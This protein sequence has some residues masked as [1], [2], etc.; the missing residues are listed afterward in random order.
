MAVYMATVELAAE[1]NRKARNREEL[2]EIVAFTLSEKESDVREA[3]KLL[4]ERDVIDADGSP[5]GIDAVSSDA[6]RAKRYRE[7]KKQS[8]DASRDD[9]GRV[10]DASRLERPDQRER[11]KDQTVTVTPVIVDKSGA[12]SFKRVGGLVS[13]LGGLQKP[14]DVRDYLQDDDFLE[15]GQYMRGWDRKELFDKF[16][17]YFASNPPKN[18][19]AAFIGWVKKFTKGKVP[20]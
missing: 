19:K 6:E 15:V 13:G 8:R 17:A 10:H 14:Y 16:S 4:E 18:H 5:V 1:D 11:E 9:N 2:I 3:I 12:G 7:K 20:A